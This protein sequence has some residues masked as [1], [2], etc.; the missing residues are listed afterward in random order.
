L[1]TTDLNLSFLLKFRG[2]ANSRK[3]GA[4]L[5]ACGPSVN[6]GEAKPYFGNFRKKT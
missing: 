6:I 2:Y 4:G 5:K 1:G 3:E